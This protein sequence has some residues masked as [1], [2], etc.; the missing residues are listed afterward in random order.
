M[1]STK[2]RWW[3]G[4]A[5]SVA[6]VS[7]T[8]LTVATSAAEETGDVA[9]TEGAFAVYMAPKGE[10]G[11]D[12]NDG[13]TPE[14]PV[15]SLP[16]VHEILSEERP[17]ADVEVRI[18]QGTYTSTPFH[19]WRFYVPG[20]S[21]SF[22]PIDYEPGDDAG[23]IA[24]LPTFRNATCDGSYCPGVWLQPRLPQDKDD[25]LYNGGDSNL[26]FYYLKVERYS[27]GG[28]SIFGN[29]E[30]DWADENYDPPLHI[31]PTKGLNNNVV[32]GMQFRNIGN[33]W[34]NGR[35]GYGGIV[36]TNSSNNRIVNSHFVNIENTDH[37]GNIHGLYV[38]HH[39][40][41]N[42]IERN[43]FSYI[44]GYPV[45]FR[46]QSNGNA[47]EENVIHRAG[48]I[49]YYRGEF[50]DTACAV[51]NNLPQQC[52]SWSNRFYYNRLQGNYAGKQPSL[53]SLGPEGLENPGG[54]PCPAA[55]G[56]KRVA[57]GGNIRE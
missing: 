6:A 31:Q 7:A 34:T 24:G 12:G 26:R 39:S 35:W 1:T 30:R 57:T 38:T 55:D 36:L 18:K 45:K 42:V 9:T 43:K 11:T 41:G 40:S 37:A 19:E 49:S 52:A 13:L 25:P 16:R 8:V 54:K 2:R 32:F 5:V 4:V 27:N 14:T 17:D 15:R 23:D 21:V 51:E 44:S 28:L 48:L 47:V 29:S 46:N 3:F 10:G 20:H 53:W 22:M 50:C 56:K 33:K